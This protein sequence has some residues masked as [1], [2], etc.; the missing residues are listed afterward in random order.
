MPRSV[1]RTDSESDDPAFH[2]EGIAS[3]LTNLST[4]LEP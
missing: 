2:A 1:A 4:Y 3:S